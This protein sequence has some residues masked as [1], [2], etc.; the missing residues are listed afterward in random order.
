MRAIF[1]R[2]LAGKGPQSMA[3][4]TDGLARLGE[5]C[6]AHTRVGHNPTECVQCNDK[7]FEVLMAA[8]LGDTAPLPLLDAVIERLERT[9]A[10]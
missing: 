2:S 10:A 6:P 9:V 5:L 7:L 1:T 8:L 4:W 3:E